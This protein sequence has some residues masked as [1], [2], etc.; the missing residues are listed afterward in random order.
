MVPAHRMTQRTPKGRI[1]KHGF[2]LDRADGMH[3]DNGHTHDRFGV[4]CLVLV[5][6]FPCLDDGV[7]DSH[8][9]ASL[10]SSSMRNGSLIAKHMARNERGVREF[11]APVALTDAGN[12]TVGIRASNALY[13]IGLPLRERPGDAPVIG[14]YGRSYW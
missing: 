12:V 3:T 14:C 11:P 13:M 7:L 9:Y 4:W 10:S 6:S 8:G 1:E 2:H 5:S